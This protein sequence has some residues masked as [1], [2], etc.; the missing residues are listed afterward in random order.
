MKRFFS[1]I[2]T[3]AILSSLFVIPIHSSAAT[4]EIR[5]GK[6]TLTSG[7]LNVRA[8]PSSSSARLTQLS[9]G[10][11]ITLRE[12]TGDWWQVE[13]ADSKLGYCHADYVTPL[14]GTAATVDT[15]GSRLNL[16]TGP[17]TSY[18]RL[19][20]LADG[21]EVVI[22]SSSGGWARILYRGSKTAYVSEQY[23]RPAVRYPALSLSVPHFKQTDSRWSW[24][25]LGTSGKTIGKVGC[26]TS[27]I[28]M[29]ESYRTG[30][31]VNPREMAGRLTYTSSGNVYW[32]S[33]YTLVTDYSLATVYRLLAEGKP[34]LFGAKNASGG[35]HWIVITG[36]A[37]GD[38]L[39]PSGFLI[40]D[41]GLSTRKTLAEFF[42]AYPYFY[43]MF[44]Y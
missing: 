40:N 11:L 21:E 41:P 2:L 1:L 10:T 15:D 4:P 33:H 26:A 20:S 22:L 18:A 38:T 32:P 37:G 9:A 39:T 14:S 19:G 23:L 43:K 8:S 27:S 12:R 24:V 3:V 16:R 31:T 30:S 29:M 25:T 36:Y 44:H 6:V 5:A 7:K 13:Y 42:T 34:V 35:Q 28:A 17:G